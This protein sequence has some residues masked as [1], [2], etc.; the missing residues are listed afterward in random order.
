[1]KL[2]LDCFLEKDYSLVEKKRV[3]L[4][5]NL[6]G[7]NQSLQPTID[8]LYQHSKVNLVSLFAPEHGIRGD[9]KEG[10]HIKFSID[11][12]LVYQSI[13]STV[14]LENPLLKCLKTLMSFFLIYKILVLAI[15][16]T[17]IQWLI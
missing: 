14:K 8:L 16:R 3:G 13:A 6:T 17:F 7:V 4:L 15:T 10:E 2:G 5:S 1:M 11:L 9:A 12:I